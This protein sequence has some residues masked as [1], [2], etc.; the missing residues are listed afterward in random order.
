M[1]QGTF[2][3]IVVEQS[4]EQFFAIASRPVK[5][6]L[7]AASFINEASVPEDA[8]VATDPGLL[9]LSNQASITDAQFASVVQEH[10]EGKAIWVAQCLSL[11]AQSSGFHRV[12]QACSQL[13]SS[14]CVDGLE[15][16]ARVSHLLI[17]TN[18]CAYVPA[19]QVRALENPT[20]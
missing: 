13:P 7:V 12:E 20:F 10:Q 14:G 16:Q 18:K 1:R 3:S 9:A 11:P 2:I 15:G 6:V 17:Q 8:Q 4:G 19:A 5:Q